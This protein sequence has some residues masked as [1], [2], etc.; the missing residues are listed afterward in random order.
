MFTSQAGRAYPSG[1]CKD[2]AKLREFRVKLPQ[3]L[4][5]QGKL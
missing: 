5:K 4:L 1:W 2:P 3:D